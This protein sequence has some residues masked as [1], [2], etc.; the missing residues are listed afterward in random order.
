MNVIEI[1]LRTAIN[2][3]LDSADSGAMP[4]VIMLDAASLQLHERAADVLKQL[5]DELVA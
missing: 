2:V 5:Q 4:A 1:A 3:F